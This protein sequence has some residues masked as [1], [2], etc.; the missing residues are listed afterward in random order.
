[1]SATSTPTPASA[2][3]SA[4]ATSPSPPVLANGTASEDSIATRTDPFNDRAPKGAP[5]RPN[6]T[7]RTVEY[8]AKPRRVCQE[9]CQR[10][11]FSFQPNPSATLDFYLKRSS[12]AG[13]R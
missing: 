3:G 8:Y 11:A 2:F 12:A 7:A 4:P 6:L 10:S 13:T 9:S 5:N 1:M